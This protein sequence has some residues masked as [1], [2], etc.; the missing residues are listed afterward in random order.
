[1]CTR[2]RTCRGSIIA[3]DDAAPRRE[4]GLAP[5]GSPAGAA[6]SYARP[7]GAASPSAGGQESA[8]FAWKACLATDAG[9]GA[10]FANPGP[11][12]QHTASSSSAGN[13]TKPTTNTLSAALAKKDAMRKER[14][15]NRRRVR[16][17]APSG[18][19]AASSRMPETGESQTGTTA[20]ESGMS[21]KE[22]E[23]LGILT[24]ESEM[25]VE[26]DNLAE[27]CVFS[28]FNVCAA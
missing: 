22:R 9:P 27:L 24:G 4:D 18:S 2:L 25:R 28:L 19:S 17:G 13:M 12:S 21:A 3:I 5:G 6:G 16:G 8:Y 15:M 11:G 14:T 23:K 26:A 10:R 7:A 1:M 20:Q